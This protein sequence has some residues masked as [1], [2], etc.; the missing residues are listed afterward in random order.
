MGDLDDLLRGEALF[1][2]APSPPDRADA[3]PAPAAPAPVT[4]EALVD[5]L[6][7]PTDAAGDLQF[8]QREGPRPS[9][10]S[11]GDP[12][13]GPQSAILLYNGVI[14]EAIL[15]PLLGPNLHTV[16]QKASK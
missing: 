9:G 3:A 1:A 4:D 2:D 16:L 5:D 6:C 10:V 14:L 12:R 15:V 13:E 11:Q 8:I 7:A